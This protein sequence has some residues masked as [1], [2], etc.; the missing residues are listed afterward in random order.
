MENK[1][2]I[3]FKKSSESWQNGSVG[4]GAVAKPSKLSTWDPHSDFAL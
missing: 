4:K 3:C 1:W 2:T